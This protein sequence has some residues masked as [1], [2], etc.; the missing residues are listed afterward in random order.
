TIN[1]ETGTPYPGGA[2]VFSGL[3]P[4]VAG[5]FGRHSNAAYAALEA[6]LTDKLSGG[7]AGRYENYSDAGSTR[8]GKLS[9]RYAF[10]DTFSMRATVSNG[11][12]AP[13]LA[14]QNYASV[15]TLPQ[16]GQLIQV[17]T[18]RTSDPIAVQLGARPLSPEKS[19]NYGIGSVWQ[20]TA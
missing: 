9:A 1:P 16:D 12:R 2:Q 5:K 20:P 8:S 17:G 13:S 4:S 10:T 18:Y 11:F 7:I 19:T 6:D 14:Q 15:V 3:E